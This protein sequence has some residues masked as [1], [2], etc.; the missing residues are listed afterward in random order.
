MV[1]GAS[2]LTAREIAEATPDPELPVVSVGELGMVRDV[3]E[4]GDAVTV[5]LTPTYSGCPALPLI[6]ADLRRR[7]AVAGYPGAEVRVALAPAWTTDWITDEGR[8]KLAAAG[9]APPGPA[10]RRTGGPVPLT[11][12]TS[13]PV[14]GPGTQAVRCPR[15]GSGRTRRTAEFGS[16]ACKALYRCGACGEPFEY[17]KEI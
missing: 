14:T 10:P 9:I 5:T 15:C 1:T 16:T 7:L 3:K 12:L 2:A 17:V 4:I 6:A 8:R 13:R 11:L